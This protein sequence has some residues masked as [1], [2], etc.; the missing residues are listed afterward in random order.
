MRLLHPRHSPSAC[1]GRCIRVVHARAGCPIALEDRHGG[2]PDGTEQRA[3]STETALVGG[4]GS[5]CASAVL[6]PVV[7]ACK[8]CFVST[9]ESSRWTHAAVARCQLPA[10]CTRAHTARRLVSLATPLPFRLAV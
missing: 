5:D 6:P 7:A 4:R 3:T 8:T 1:P 10:Y 2:R 9:S